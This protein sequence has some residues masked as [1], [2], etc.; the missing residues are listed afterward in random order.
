MGG[1][2]AIQEDSALLVLSSKERITDTNFRSIGKIIKKYHLE[3]ERT[4]QTGK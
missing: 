3:C 2:Q 4:Y 1:I